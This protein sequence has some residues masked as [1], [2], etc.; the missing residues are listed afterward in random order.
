MTELSFGYFAKGS[1]KVIYLKP[2]LLSQKVMVKLRVVMLNIR[3]IFSHFNQNIWRL[4]LR[5]LKI[6]SVQCLIFYWPSEW[7]KCHLLQAKLT[8]KNKNNQT[9]KRRV[10][11][12]V[13]W[14]I[15]M[16]L[17]TSSVFNQPHHRH[18]HGVTLLSNIS[19]TAAQ[20]HLEVPLA[21]KDE[22]KKS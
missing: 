15:Q 5:E 1:S 16:P 22:R 14:G 12:R 7:P 21:T 17:R 19:Q 6:P 20:C 4:V 8:V 11:M 3:A 18:K 2:F 13:K 9:E 10:S